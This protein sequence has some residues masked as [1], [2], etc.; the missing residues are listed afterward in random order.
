MSIGR[1]PRRLRRPFETLRTIW[2]VGAFS[3]PH[4]LY[5]QWRHRSEF[6]RVRRA[7]FYHRWTSAL[8]LGHE[9]RLFDALAQ[10]PLTAEEAAAATKIHARAAEAILRVLES[11]HHLAR[12]GAHF[13]LSP[14]ARDYLTRTGSHSIAPMLDLMAAQASA[15]AELPLAMATG[16]VPAPLD[17]FSQASRYQAFLDGV[18]DYLS[19]AGRE[20][21]ARASLGPVRS[22][23][24]GS[25][26]VSMSAIVLEKFPSARVTYGCLSHLV[27]EIPR[28][29]EKYRIDGAR[30]DGMYA[31]G[32]DPSADHWGDEAYDLVFLTKKMI[33]LPEE[34]VGEKFAKKAFEVLRPGGTAIFWETVHTDGAPTP[35]LRAMEAVLDLGAGPTG[36]VNTEAGLTRTLEG[37]GYQRIEIVPCLNGL[38]TFVVA[39][40]C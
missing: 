33:L 39:R 3:R 1:L 4:E 34:R 28:L 2:S 8:L 37:I 9:L 17:I 35:L 26:G 14:F 40:K 30:V 31:H 21:L 36:L 25:M 32:G 27:R 11:E 20:L 38:T 13:G 24:V 7:L 18:N 6:A 10:T 15:F 12:D 29:R 16:R 5:S 22:F 23:I 19:W